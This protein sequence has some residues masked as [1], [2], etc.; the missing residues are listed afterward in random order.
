MSRSV[1]S[2]GTIGASFADD[3]HTTAWLAQFFV[4]ADCRAIG[5]GKALWEHLWAVLRG[6]PRLGLGSFRNNAHIGFYARYGFRVLDDIGAG[7]SSW[8][9]LYYGGTVLYFFP[10]V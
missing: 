3:A 6:T 4:R 10:H 2:I 5:L 9:N 1:V 7:K 8:D